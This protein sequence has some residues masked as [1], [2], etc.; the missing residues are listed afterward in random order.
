ETTSRLPD[1][2]PSLR[3]AI[4][5]V[6]GVCAES[7]VQSVALDAVSTML[8]P[9]RSSRPTPAIPRDARCVSALQEQGAGDFADDL[10]GHR[11][12]EVAQI[13]RWI[14]LDDVGAD[15]RAVER[16][17]HLQHVADREAAGLAMRDA[18]REAGIEAV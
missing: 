14:D 16:I 12:R 4:P 1:C 7:R 17:N 11:C 15:D 5:I 6:C 10:R 8:A 2:A 3:R 18:G 13:L 9:G